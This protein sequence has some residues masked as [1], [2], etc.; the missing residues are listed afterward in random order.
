LEI[1]S[2]QGLGTSTQVQAENGTTVKIFEN[3]TFQSLEGNGD[4]VLDSAQIITDVSGFDGDIFGT[5]GVTHTGTGTHSNVIY[6]S[7]Y[8]GDF[9]M[10]GT[11]ALDLTFS[12]AYSGDLTLSDGTLD[13][14]FQ[15]TFG[16][17]L[18]FTKG[19]LI[20]NEQNGVTGPLGGYFSDTNTLTLDSDRSVEIGPLEEIGGLAGSGNLVIGNEVIFGGNS[21]PTEFSGT[22]SGSGN[23]HKA[24]NS[25]LELTGNANHTGETI[26]EDGRLWLQTTGTLSS[27]S[28]IEVQSMGAFE[29]TGVNGGFTL[30]KDQVLKGNGAVIGAFSIEGTI[31]PGSSVGTLSTNAHVDLKSGATYEWEI[32]DWSGSAGTGYDQWTPSTI[33][34][35]GPWTVKIVD[36]N[37]VNFSETNQI[38]EII[39]GSSSNH[40]GF[41]VNNV[42]IDTS[43]A[44]TSFGG[45][46]SIQ[47]NSDKIELVYTTADTDGPTITLRGTTPQF[48]ECATANYVEAGASASDDSGETFDTDDAPAT[49]TIGG[50]PINVLTLGNYQVTYDVSDSAGNPATTVTRTVIVRDTTSPTLFGVGPPVLLECASSTYAPFSLTG[51]DACDGLIPAVVGGDVIPVDGSGIVTTPG[52]YTETYTATDSSGNSSQVSRTVTVQDTTGPAISLNGSSPMFIECNIETYSEPNATAQDSCEGSI[53][54]NISGDTVKEDELGDYAV[55]YSAFDSA[56]NPASQV[57]RTVTV[58]GKGLT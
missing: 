1:H 51:F 22:T 12:D 48:I 42:T 19:S 52:T 29:V 16:G 10:N 39:N 28:A 46:W 34:F 58:R 41:D 17:T 33:D 27:T 56:G 18:I 24:G 14:L 2:D 54:V 6:T 3:S 5:G 20:L 9:E 15:G 50:V 11:G 55:N 40:V 7:V 53:T 4:L 32:S 57:T 31:A 45:T 13:V 23:F 8:T 21:L 38:F 26:I 49:F 35:L 43:G 30:G 25:T 36:L 47:Q 37:M 44:S